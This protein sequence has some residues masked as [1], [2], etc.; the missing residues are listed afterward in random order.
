MPR[1]I[2]R[3]GYRVQGST[4]QASA[5]AHWSGFSFTGGNVQVIYKGPWGQIQVWASSE[6]EGR[7]VIGHA[8]AHA[9]IS[10]SDP[11]GDWQVATPAGGRWRQGVRYRVKMKYGLPVVTARPGPEGPAFL[12]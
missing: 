10:T 6:S 2:K 9:G 7:R 8:C 3:L 12:E 11:E 1:G 4:S 5:A